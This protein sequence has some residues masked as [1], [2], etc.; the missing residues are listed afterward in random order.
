MCALSETKSVKYGGSIERDS[1][2]SGGASDLSGEGG[3]SGRAGVEVSS[4]CGGGQG[5]KELAVDSDDD[6]GEGSEGMLERGDDGRK[7]G[8]RCMPIVSTGLVFDAWPRFV[9]F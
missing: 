5:G 4:T 2:V 9:A 8:K 3:G 6:E 1:A 7:M